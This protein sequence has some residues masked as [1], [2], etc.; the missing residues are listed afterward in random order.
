MFVF[1]TSTNCLNS[2]ALKH[3]KTRRTCWLRSLDVGDALLDRDIADVRNP[4]GP[5]RDICGSYF[6]GG[7]KPDT[8]W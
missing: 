7:S 3:L 5:T 1:V 4:G 2:Q 8:L 6:L